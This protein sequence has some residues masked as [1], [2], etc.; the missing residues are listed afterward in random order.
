[1]VQVVLD[2]KKITL[3]DKDVIG[4]GG[5]ANV[6]KLNQQAVKLYLA[7][8]K[9]RDQKLRALLPRVQGLPAQVIAPQ[10]LIFDTQQKNVVGFTM[11]L[12]TADFTEVRQ[13]SSRKYRGMTG[14]TAREVAKLF[15]HAGQ[16][17]RTIHQAGMIVGDLNDL[18][19]MFRDGEMLY[20]D[21][22]SFQ[23]DQ[24]PCMVGTEAFIDPS[25]YNCNL[26]AR[27]M[28][29]PDHDW[30]SFAVLLFKSLLLVH[31][32][33]GV[34]KTVNMLTQR[35]HQR[36]S[37]FKSDVTYPRIAYPL[38][39][40]DDTL[41]GTF[42]E[43]F[44]QGKRGAFPVE[45]IEMYARSLKVCSFCGDIY[46]AA[47]TRC[48]HCST[49]IPAAVIVQA[50]L[51]TIAQS[52]GTFVGWQVVGAIARLIA[53]EDG[54]VVLYELKGQQV[55]KRL[56][57]FDAMPSAD[58]AFLGD[59]LIISPAVDSPDL[60][61]VDNS[62][63]VPKPVL[64]TTTGQFGNVE[65]VFGAGGQYMYRLA[66]GFLMRGEFRLGQYTEQAVMAISDGQTWLRVAPDGEHVFGFFR[67][68][69]KYN[70]WLLNGRTH[71]DIELAPLE[72]TE[73][74]IDA[75]VK[76]HTQSA[77]LVRLTQL[78]GVDYIRLDEIEYSGKVKFST[79]TKAIETFT[80]LDAHAYA[81]NV[82]VYATDSGI[83]RE[84]LDN[85]SKTTFAQTDQVVQSGHRV[86]A[87]EQGLLVLSDD[88]ALYLAN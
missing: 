78:N 22:D 17:L 33:G 51:R 50:H 57:L 28:F 74:V 32:Y 66:G 27:P 13:L 59:L 21:T 31:P 67:V 38:E 84:Q 60:L 85:G 9:D 8:D 37:I 24:Y 58:Y 46:P 75:S 30:Y 1:M 55:E 11:R 12:L 88:K 18:N 3:T 64:Q 54:E 36:L 6:F 68:F 23:F 65:R 73:F 81:R 71:L 80:P 43:W 52:K 45:Q 62:S 26:A 72:A 10:A 53:H 25:L 87:Y 39:M 16:T 82:L 35:A 44:T 48:P 2:G 86:F 19:L 63:G 34:H 76:F 69:N 61:V 49:V 29:K 7:P 15:Y 79:K 83:V 41:L 5:E 47:R 56:V 14:V 20:I 4:V 42:D 77:L 70:H 40:I